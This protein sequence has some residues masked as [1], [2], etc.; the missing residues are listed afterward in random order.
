LSP[1]NSKQALVKAKVV[2]VKSKSGGVLF[3]GFGKNTVDP[4]QIEQ[5]FKKLGVSVDWTRFKEIRENRNDI[6]H[7]YSTEKHDKI[8]EIISNAFVIVR[9]F[10]R[11]ELDGDPRKLLGDECW[12]V[13][14][15][16]S[17]VFESERKLCL[18]ALGELDWDGEAE[19]AVEEIRCSSCGSSLIM[20]TE[21]REKSIQDQYFICK[22]CG[23]S[24]PFTNL[25]VYSSEG[26]EEA[27]TLL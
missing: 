14:L 16:E 8:R 1:P 5:H 18:E 17:Q 9:D 20:P 26:S 6:E 3:E 25:E 24:I 4:N 7:Y 22:S 12:Q 27:S 19:I 15:Q 11:D 23:S 10:I 2:P 13:L 21:S